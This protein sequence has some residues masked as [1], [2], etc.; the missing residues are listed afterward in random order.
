M[1]TFA[2]LLA[3]LMITASVA[4]QVNVPPGH[5]VATFAEDASGAWSR[6]TTSYPA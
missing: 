4:A 5:A 3:T 6:P 2:A 1:K